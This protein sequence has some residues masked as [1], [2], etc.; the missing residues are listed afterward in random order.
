VSDVLLHQLQHDGDNGD[1]GGGAER[2]DGVRDAEVLPRRLPLVL[3]LHGVL[4]LP[5]PANV[6]TYL[7]E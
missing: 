6:K 3:V 4:Q 7:T 5:A 1:N 2:E